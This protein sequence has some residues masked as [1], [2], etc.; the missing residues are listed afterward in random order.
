MVHKL[1]RLLSQKLVYKVLFKETDDR[2]RLYLCRAVRV[3]V[4][5]MEEERE[6]ESER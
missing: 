4:D 6:R 3:L 5:S 1:V 2:I